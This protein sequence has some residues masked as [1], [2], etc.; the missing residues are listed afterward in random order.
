MSQSGQKLGRSKGKSKADSFVWT[1]DE[2]LQSNIRSPRPRKMSIGNHARQ[3]TLI[4]S[5][6]K[7]MCL[8]AIFHLGLSRGIYA[9]SNTVTSS[10]S[11]KF[12]FHRLQENTKT[13]FSKIFTLK[14]AFEKL[15]FR[16][17]GHRYH[18]IRLD[19]RPLLKE[20]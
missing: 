2:Q 7:A 4:F 6:T 9:G 8:S 14:G 3:N 1:D 20:N 16:L 17:F 19:G 10:F 13:A 11:K 12:R 5:E 15:R 18:R